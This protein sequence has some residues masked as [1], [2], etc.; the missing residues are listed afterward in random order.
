MITDYIYVYTDASTPVRVRIS[1]VVD[2]YS[3]MYFLH[4]IALT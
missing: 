1:L 4:D 2:L 3:L